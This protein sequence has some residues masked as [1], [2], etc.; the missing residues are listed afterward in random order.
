M[1]TSVFTWC[2]QEQ[3]K[4]EMILLRRKLKPIAVEASKLEK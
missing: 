2:L 1:V 4:L 3:S